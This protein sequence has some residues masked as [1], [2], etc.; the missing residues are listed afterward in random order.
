MEERRPRHRPP[1]SE[2][3]SPWL[4]FYHGRGLRNQSFY[5]V[6]KPNNTYVR[7]IPELRKKCVW[8]CCYGW[9]ILSN[10]KDDQFSLWNP[11][12]L[13]SIVLPLLKINS[14]TC[15]NGAL[16]TSP[17]S[18]P[19][20]SLLIFDKGL[21][22]ILFCRLQNQHWI[23][24]S[25][26][27]EMEA[28]G[29]GSSDFLTHPVSCNGKLY[30]ST[31]SFSQLVSIEQ[32]NSLVIRS[33]GSSKP[34]PA[35]YLSP[36]QRRDLVESCGDLFAIITID[37]GIIH[38]DAI[39]IEIFKLD[40][41]SMIW[42]RVESVRDRVFFLC[43]NYALSC[44]T[45]ISSEQ[46]NGN[47]VYFTRWEDKSLYSY[48]MDDGSI[49][50]SL[51]CPNIPTP[52]RSPIWVMP[53]FRLTKSFREAMHT[54][55]REKQEEE[56]EEDDEGS[57]KKKEVVQRAENIEKLEKWGA[58]GLHLLDLPS[59]LL[60]SISELL[61]SVDYL[62]FRAVCKMTRHVAPPIEWRTRMSGSDQRR[63]SLSP[64][65]MNFEKSK[66]VCSFVDPNHGDKYLIQ[67]PKLLQDATLCYCKDGWLLM[68]QP[69]Y[70]EEQ[71]Q[72]C[73]IFFNP[74]TKN[75]IP[76]PA[77]PPLFSN[78]S[79][80]SF[81]SAPSSADCVVVVVTFLYCAVRVGVSRS[82]EE[83]WIQMQLEIEP[84]FFPGFTVPVFINGAFYFMN[85][86]G[87]LG[88]LSL[89]GG[90]HGGCNWKTLEYPRKPCNGFNN[91]LL[92]ECDGQ[93][94]SVFMGDFG[95]WVQVFKLNH[96]TMVWERVENLGNRTLYISRSSAL[97]TVATNSKLENKI[98]IPRFCGEG[99]VSYSL[100]TGMYQYSYGC[101]GGSLKDYQGTRKLLLCGWMEPR[102]Y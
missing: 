91:N 45:E 14:E 47:C 41:S 96:S 1:P 73:L 89:E 66:G 84:F 42:E 58:K 82:R 38:E 30:A 69:S 101:E 36:H 32:N 8:N 29:G 34:T 65:L 77:L 27:K 13:E 92:A 20:C 55:T 24:K 50:A 31:F 19:N 15:I 6:S 10:Y 54:S 68:C 40:F 23:E 61:I 11:A 102:W 46:I 17:P 44:P 79:S 21:R 35:E 71:S 70:S 83:E 22:R 78:A 3:S 48:N 97:S 16:L 67:I 7:S 26:R 57:G 95:K 76:Y 63:Y 4:V 9:L 18:E 53:D 33:R 43:N 5:S 81:S 75:I 59:D 80:F 99:I 87:I 56:E 52:W 88:V 62:K 12:T 51:P 49:S 39:G 25:Y 100:S 60:K 90:D 94:I 85:M 86:D 64:W 93:L 72:L 37:G 74:F 28:M 98:F 2:A